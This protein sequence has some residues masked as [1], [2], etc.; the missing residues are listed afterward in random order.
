MVVLWEV[1]PSQGAVQSMDT[2]ASCWRSRDDLRVVRYVIKRDDSHV[3]VFRWL[4][5]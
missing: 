4:E 1:T 2:S 3:D 5:I